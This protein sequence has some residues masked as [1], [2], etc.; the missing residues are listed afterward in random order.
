MGA[1]KEIGNLHFTLKGNKLRYLENEAAH[2]GDF[3]C[4]LLETL[5]EV[6]RQDEVS[7]LPPA[8]VNID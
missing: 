7:L 5:K 4:L 6:L 2:V 3:G 8:E 1:E